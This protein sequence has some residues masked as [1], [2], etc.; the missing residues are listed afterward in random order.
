MVIQEPSEMSD[1]LIRVLIADDHPIVRDG[2]NAVIN[3]Q[4]DM[5][6]VAE[7]AN[8]NET[9]QLALEHRPDVLLVDLR[10]PQLNG[11]EVINAIR[12]DWPQA[13]IIILTTY[14]GE[15]DI[16]QALQAGAQAYLLKGM[17]RA[18]LLD[19]IRAV[20]AGRKRI[21]PEVASKLAE[22]ISASE[23][24]ERELEVLELIVAGQ[25]N[26]E[27]GASLSITEG[28]VK[29]HVNSILGKLGVQDRT[30]AVTEALRRGIVHLE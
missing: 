1:A 16:Y 23:L 25:S 5:E 10:M 11:L 19:T 17:P 21:P 29:A 4:P 12:A 6:V 3:D 30:Q 22:R 27:I 2:L 26:K 14:D 28:T 7:A 9:V 8:G 18:E 20:H 24:T 15:E 13:R